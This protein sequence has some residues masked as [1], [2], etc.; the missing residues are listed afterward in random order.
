V[1]ADVRA[2][3]A[4][5]PDDAAERALGARLAAFERQVGPAATSALR[6]SRPGNM[7]VTLH[8]LGEIDAAAVEAVKRELEPPLPLAAFPVALGGVGAFPRGGPPEVFWVGL[9][10][11]REPCVAIH[12]ELAT[13]LARAG[14][15]TESRPFAPHVTLAR[16]RNSRA[17]GARGL[18]A[19]VGALTFEPV[20]WTVTGVTFF[21]SDLSGAAPRYEALAQCGVR[22]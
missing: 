10:E 6:W 13:R 11:G 4:I 22:S 17:P 5:P 12:A 20:R 16:V 15:A 2:F 14:I 18:R 21:R 3:I 1:G 7:H 19:R 8:F 9:V